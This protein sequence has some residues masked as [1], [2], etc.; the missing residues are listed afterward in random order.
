[1][2][3]IR[4]TARLSETIYPVMIVAG[5]IWGATGEPGSGLA[6]LVVALVGVI[7]RPRWS[8]GSRRPLQ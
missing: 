7:S 6:A 2:N 3:S 5:G 8:M 4:L 1:M